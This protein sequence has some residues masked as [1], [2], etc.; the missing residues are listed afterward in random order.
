MYAAVLCVAVARRAEGLA[1]DH[2]CQEEHDETEAHRDETTRSTTRPER[3]RRVVPAFRTA[4]VV[5]L[6]PKTDGM[7]YV[8]VAL[9]R[10]T[11]P[12]IASIHFYPVK[13]ARGLSLQ[14]AEVLRGGLRHDRRF[15]VVDEKGVFVTQRSHP[16]MALVDVAID[17][18]T[19][20]LC[21][22]GQTARVDLAPLYADSTRTHPRMHV[23]IWK[24]EVDAIDVGGN[25]AELFSRY[26]GERCSLVFMPLDV[27]RPV[28]Q[29]YGQPGDRVGFADGYPVLIACASSLDDLN[30][31][32][33]AE[34]SPPIPMNRFRPS[35][36]VEGG[37]PFAEEAARA[38]RIGAL[39]L[40]TPKRCSRCEVT[41]VDQETAATG[42]EPLRTLARYRKDGSKV[43]FAMNAIPDLADDASAFVAVGDEVTYEHP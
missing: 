9:S 25:G 40:R 6:D 7:R 23:R 3:R 33:A 30:E 2:S 41:T 39:R 11:S 35:L 13:G 16:R 26:L 17:D 38:V 31:R 29:P 14:R 36:V 32:I 42:R 20:T 12:R 10:S 28:E 43:Y 27:V 18:A 37:A 1:C 22:D 34:G 21:A 5:H 19:L 24:D 4:R 8:V 15:L